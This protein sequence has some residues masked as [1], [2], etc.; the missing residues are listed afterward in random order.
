MV[1]RQVPIPRII[2]PRAYMTAILGG[3]GVGK[4]S[5]GVQIPGHYFLLTEVGTGGVKPYGDIIFNWKGF[6]E[7]AKE[8]IAAK[9]TGWKDQR[10]IS[11]INVDTLDN[12]FD[13]ACA[14]VCATQTF[15][16]K[17]VAH[18]YTK[19][20]DV[21]WGKGYKAAYQ[22]MLRN[23]EQLR[24]HGFGVFLYGHTKERPVKWAGEDLQHKGFNLPPSATLAV[25]AACDAVGHFEM[26]ETIQK[27]PT[28]GVI[29]KVEQSRKM[30]WQPT[31]LRL[32]KHR[33]EGF[34]AE[35]D[36][37]MNKGWE[38]YCEAFATTVQALDEKQL[39]QAQALEYV[40]PTQ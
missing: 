27:D 24:L 11:T 29:L 7:K 1:L 18:K 21:P 28:T 34:P 4:T 9:D 12:L 20:D 16:E 31:F 23:L 26:T 10:V 38:T 39:A 32:A 2:D 19:V 8:I 37:P 15:I 36:L 17:G 14:E 22:L 6:I 25:Q 30:Y 35:L 5:F 3:T 13:Y 40:T 33:L